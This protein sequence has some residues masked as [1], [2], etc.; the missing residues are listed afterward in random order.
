V[1]LKVIQRVVAGVQGIVDKINED[2]YPYRFIVSEQGCCCL[3]QIAQTYIIRIMQEVARLE[4]HAPLLTFN[5]SKGIQ[6]DLFIAKV[7]SDD[8]KE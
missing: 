1:D 8:D 5:K 4:D 7:T 6:R 3:H 2:M